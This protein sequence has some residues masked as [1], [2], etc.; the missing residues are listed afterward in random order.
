MFHKQNEVLSSIILFLV[1]APSYSDVIDIVIVY[2]VLMV[3]EDWLTYLIL[4]GVVELIT[5]EFF[6]VGF[7]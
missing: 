3:L 4:L 1:G 6:D 7:I 5:V 2:V